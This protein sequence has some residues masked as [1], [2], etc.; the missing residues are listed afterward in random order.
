MGCVQTA[1][2]LDSA[3]GHDIA[4]PSAIIAECRR[5]KYTPP[6]ENLKRTSL[7]RRS[8]CICAV[9]LALPATAQ[10]TSTKFDEKYDF[11]LHRRYKWRENRLMTRQHPDTNEEI[12][13][14][15]AKA[16]NRLRAKGFVENPGKA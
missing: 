9:F 13:L 14:K 2:R 11:S 6:I 1:G 12:D 4:V 10:K 16:V 15:I 7:L 3:S 8:V 5:G